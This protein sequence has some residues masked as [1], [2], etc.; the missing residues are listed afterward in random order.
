MAMATSA[1]TEL[2]AL[3][4]DPERQAQAKE[5]ARIRR[6]LLAVE[7]GIGLAFLLIWW[8]SGLTFRLRD[9]LAG[10]PAWAGLALYLIAFGASYTALTLPLSWYAGFALP[11][12]YGLS[13]RSL[14]SWAL[15][16]VKGLAVAG[17]L[18][19][20]LAEAIYALLRAQPDRWWIWAGLAYLAFTVALVHLAPVLIAPLFYKFEPLIERS[21]DAQERARAQALADRLTRLAERAG[22]RVRGVYAF[23]M[24]RTTTAANAALIGLGN[25]RR[26]ILADTLLDRYTPDE[27]ETILAHELAHQVHNDTGKG[28]AFATALILPGFYLAHLALWWGA[29]H[30]GFQGIADLA[31]IP[32]FALVM[33]GFLLVTLPLQ[34]AWSRWRERLADRYALEATGRPHAFASAMMRLANQNLA[35][36]EPPRWVVWLLHSHPPTGERI[37]MAERYAQA[38][39]DRSSS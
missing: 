15:D 3:R 25:T 5:Y 39:R 4:L 29:S 35:E 23:N 2:D 36:A 13:T 27:I 26:I 7:L 21:D 10:L 31:A 12:R 19:L 20:S 6:R 14:R 28:I 32:W 24:S 8:W 38:M 9:A 22:T 30:F 18:L 11:H 16:E 37:R 1:S 33:S 34:N 17:F